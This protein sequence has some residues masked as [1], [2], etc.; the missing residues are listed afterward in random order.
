MKSL[1]AFNASNNSFIGQ[2]PTVFCVSAPSFAVLELSYNQ[3]SG[4]IPQELGNCSMLTSL[5]AGHNIS[6]T[7]PDE[8]FSITSMEHLS[9]HDNQLERT[10][11]GISRLKNLATLN[12]GGNMFSGNIPSAIGELKKLVTI[13]LDHNSMSGVKSLSDRLSNN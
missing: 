5:N 13:H 7:L 3:F 9:L 6:G 11:S 1:I 2:I 12:L 4:R 10:L 8:L